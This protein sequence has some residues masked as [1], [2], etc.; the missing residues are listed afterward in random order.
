MKA[1]LILLFIAIEFKG[2]PDDDVPKD[3]SF[4]FT[5]QFTI[6]S[7]DTGA[8]HIQVDIKYLII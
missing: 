2:K 7:N 4:S 6:C 1:V 3:S 5:L 8:F